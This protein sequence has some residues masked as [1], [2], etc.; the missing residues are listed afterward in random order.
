M[1]IMSRISLLLLAAIAGCNFGEAFVA[2][3]KDFPTAGFSVASTRTTY[4]ILQA[5]KGESKKDNDD[6]ISEPIS[7]AEL[8]RLEQEQSKKVIDR[9]TFPQRLGDA[10]QKLAWAWLI[11]IYALKFLGYGWFKSPD[12]PFLIIDTLENHSFQETIRKSMKDQAKERPFESNP[13]VE[14]AAF[15]EEQ[16][17]MSVLSGK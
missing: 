7:L 4:S 17:A 16:A 11:S 10:F 1:P 14:R 15:I 2:P 3:N 9:L 12:G 13:A 6:E 5:K 8:S